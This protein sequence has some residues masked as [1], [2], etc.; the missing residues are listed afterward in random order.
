MKLEH[1]EVGNYEN[2]DQHG[3][4]KSPPSPDVVCLPAP[5]SGKQP[6]SD[7]GLRRHNSAPHEILQWRKSSIDRLEQ[8]G[9]H[10]SGPGYNVS[11]DSPVTIRKH[12][13]LRTRHS[14]VMMPCIDATSSEWIEAYRQGHGH[15]PSCVAVRLRFVL[16]CSLTHSSYSHSRL[17]SLWLCV[18][19]TNSIAGGYQRR[20]W[21]FKL[22]TLML[23]VA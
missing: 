6:L 17:L 1:R 4:T 15:T 7:T 8:T 23:N 21:S 9:S 11:R 3:T 20:P 10:A 22:E 16:I 2:I 12:D 13:L 18:F 19:G 14:L 5:Y